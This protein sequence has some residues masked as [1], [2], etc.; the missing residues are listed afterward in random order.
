MRLPLY[1]PKEGVPFPQFD[2]QRIEGEA[3]EDIVKRLKGRACE[4]LGECSEK[5]YTT[6][7]AEGGHISC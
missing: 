6:Q 7:V 3:D 5:E 4:N 1:G 2:R